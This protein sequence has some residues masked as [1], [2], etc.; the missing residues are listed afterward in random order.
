[1]YHPA[2]AAIS[3]PPTYIP[4]RYIS[5]PLQKYNPF[6][7]KI[8]TPSDLAN[9]VLEK[10]LRKQGEKEQKDTKPEGPPAPQ[11]AA[12]NNATTIFKPEFEIPGYV[13]GMANEDVDRIMEEEAEKLK[14]RRRVYEDS[15]GA[16]VLDPMPV[17]RRQFERKVVFR[18][19]RRRGRVDHAVKLA[20]TE[21]SYLYKSEI[22]KTSEKKLTRIMHQI[23]GKTL[24]EAFVQLRF[25]KKKVAID[26]ARLLDTARYAA[27]LER[28]MGLGAIESPDGTR[29]IARE[30]EPV[31]IELKD[32]SRKI[33]QDPTEMY[34]DQAW[35]GRSKPTHS[36]EFRARGRVNKLTHRRTST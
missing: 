4:R 14:M 22:L 19:L 5:N 29:K 6:A 18:S 32:G 26:V 30:G 20:R 9:P 12:I 1:M 15:I 16:S 13:E 3:R 2:L 27:T 23:A 21:R 8:S 36:R 35:V 28:G 7:P 25:S 10:L 11:P 17:R 33:I 34:I 31:Q 24:E